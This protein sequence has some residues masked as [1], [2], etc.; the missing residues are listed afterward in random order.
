MYKRKT[1]EEDLIN[2]TEVRR[3]ERIKMIILR[4]QDSNKIR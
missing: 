2:L 3:G 1:K 4:R